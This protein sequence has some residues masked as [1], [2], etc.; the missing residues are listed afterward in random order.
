MKSA[1]KLKSGNSPLYKNLG[2][3]P[4]KKEKTKLTPEAGVPYVTVK[5]KGGKTTYHD[6]T[7]DVVETHIDETK[8][9]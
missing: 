3:S 6:K 2:S 8:N 7:G 5:T 4:M 9:K 1:F